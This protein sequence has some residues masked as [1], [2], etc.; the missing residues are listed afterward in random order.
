MVDNIF[1]LTTNSRVGLPLEI[2]FTNHNIVSLIEILYH[3]RWNKFLGRKFA[4]LYLEKYGKEGREILIEK[5]INP[6]E[7]TK[8]YA[9]E[10]RVYGGLH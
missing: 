3:K 8:E 1:H 5:G 9:E 7:I 10:K 4:I 6:D 2:D